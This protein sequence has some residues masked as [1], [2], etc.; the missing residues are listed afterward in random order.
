MAIAVID[1]ARIMGVCRGLRC[2]LACKNVNRWKCLRC[3]Y[4]Y[5]LLLFGYKRADRRGSTRT[6]PPRGKC[7]QRT[8]VQNSSIH[9]LK[10]ALLLAHLPPGGYLG[11]HV[12]GC[13]I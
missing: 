12:I 2:E 10:K 7:S 1:P 13:L 6:V 3:A 9:K 8:L 5:F 11:F 4:K